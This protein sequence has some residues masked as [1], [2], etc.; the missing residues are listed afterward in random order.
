MTGIFES[1]FKEE[2]ITSNWYSDIEFTTDSNVFI[3]I[4]LAEY[5]ASISKPKSK[6]RY[7]EYYGGF[8]NSSEVLVW[9]DILRWNQRIYKNY[10]PKRHVRGS[11]RSDN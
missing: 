4:S 1:E 7:W 6:N 2:Y 3:G 11:R 10:T 5:E 9:R 8:P